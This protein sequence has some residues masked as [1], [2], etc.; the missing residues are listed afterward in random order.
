MTPQY[1]ANEFLNLS[2]LSLI[3]FEYDLYKFFCIS[4]I[5]KFSNDSNL[6]IKSDVLG[7]SYKILNPINPLI[8]WNIKNQIL[9]N[10]FGKEQKRINDNIK[11]NIF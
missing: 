7:K 10:C 9:Q 6:L 2:L 3:N 11:I 1:K 4:L 8:T 5:C